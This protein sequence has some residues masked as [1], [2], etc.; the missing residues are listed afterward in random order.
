VGVPAAVARPADHGRHRAFPRAPRPP[1]GKRTL[2]PG[3]RARAPVEAQARGFV[4]HRAAQAGRAGCGRQPF[5]RVRAPTVASGSRGARAPTVASG[6]CGAPTGDPAGAAPR[7]ADP[8]TARG[9]SGCR[10]SAPQRACTACAPSARGARASRAGDPDLG[11]RAGA[12]R[13][14]GQSGGQRAG[15]ASGRTDAAG[16]RADAPCGR[17]GAANTRHGRGAWRGQ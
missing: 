12:A 4:D 14:G 7:G 10:G 17:A 6:S 3:A 2:G 1:R 5:G 9:A 11:S 13:A 16:S 8:S 15:A